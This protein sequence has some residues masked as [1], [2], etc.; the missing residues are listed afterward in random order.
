MLKRFMIDALI[1]RH[2]N[3][4][5]ASLANLQR[6]SELDPRNGE[7]AYRLGQ[8]YFEMRRYSEFEQLIRKEAVSG[9]CPTRGP[10]IQTW[11]AQM[12]L[13]QGD[14]VAAESL[15]KQVPLDSESMI[16][17]GHTIHGSPL[18]AGL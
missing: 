4:W 1:G 2:Q 16:G 8:I 13:A 12:K 9:D 18:S 10:F 7:V 17:L 14:P 5:D 6:A 15:L 11:L 3:S